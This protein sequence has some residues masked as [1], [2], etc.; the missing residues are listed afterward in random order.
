MRAYGEKG[1][2]N[3]RRLLSGETGNKLENL[4]KTHTDNLQFRDSAGLNKTLMLHVTAALTYLLNSVT[5]SLY[6][7]ELL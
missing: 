5:V 1:A 2:N 7:L 3:S 6:F 4:I